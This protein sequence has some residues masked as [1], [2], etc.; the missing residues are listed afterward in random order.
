MPPLVDVIRTLRTMPPLPDVAHR[1]LQIVNDPEYSLDSLVQVVR[2]DP[3]LTSRILTLCNSSL[4]G[5]SR[6]IT[7][8]SEAV[9]YLGTRN[10]VKLV[11]VT[12]TVAYHRGAQHDGYGGPRE[13]WR[14]SLACA[15][16]CQI[17]AE[18]CGYDQPGTAFTAGILHNIGKIAV[19]QIAGGAA[20]APDPTRSGA[21]P[22]PTQHLELERQWLGIDHA[23]ASG[24]VAECWGLPAD[25][26]RAVRN[27]H[28]GNLIRKDGELT[29]LLHVADTLVLGMGIGNP[30]PSI[31]QQVLPEALD[32]LHLADSDLPG[33]I[34]RVDV[35]L[36]RSA[37]LLNLAG[38]PDR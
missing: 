10:L 36:G 6:E 22:A 33:I 14:H 38:G 7:T 18:F 32:R 4:H 11:L 20:A 13:L 3:A 21:A 34:A 25:L 5:L 35:E 12:C 31:G 9:A 19:V 29:A 30:F 8:V 24:I 27:H 23:A 28:D 17:T 16:A 15:H 2:V 26:R 37:E 1:V